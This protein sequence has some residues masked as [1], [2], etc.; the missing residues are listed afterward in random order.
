[1]TVDG[2]IDPDERPADAAVRECWEETGCSLNLPAY[3]VFSAVPS[4][5]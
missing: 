1:M 3:W 2:A 5:G 4:S